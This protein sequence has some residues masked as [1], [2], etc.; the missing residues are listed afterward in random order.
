M[1]VRPPDRGQA[2]VE[3]VALLP[4]LAVAA[5]A[6]VQVLAAGLAR[7]LADHAAE[8]GAVAILEKQDP[9]QAARSAV[10]GWSRDRL[11]VHV[12][13][14]RVSVRVAAPAVIAPLADRLA[15]EAQAV[16]GSS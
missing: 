7:E 9:A 4:V 11:S 3:T 15:G 12:A 10:P 16:A 2:T 8:A 1:R 14:R 5:F 6:A 13:G